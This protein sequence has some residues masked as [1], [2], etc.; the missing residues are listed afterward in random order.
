MP[1]RT[2]AGTDRCP[3]PA[4]S[5]APMKVDFYR[6]TLGDDELES[7]RATLG[8][9]FLT[10]GPRVGRFEEAFAARL[11]VPFVVGC[12]SCTTGLTL[13][14]RAMDIGPGDEVITTPMTFCSTSNTIH[15]IGARHVFADIDPETGILDPERVKDKITEKTKAIAVVHLYGQLAP[16]KAFRALADAHGL[17][18]IEDAAH[19]VESE[20]E[21]VT[22][23]Q[24][25]DAAIFSFYA[26]KVMT[27]GDG[28]AIAV[29]DEGL[30]DR[31]RRL[32]NHG[33]SKDAAA[34]HGGLYQHWDM[35]ELGYKAAMTD[36]EAALLLPQ[37][38]RIDAQ[39]AS[40]TALVERYEH[41]LADHPDLELVARNGVS[42]HHLMTVR[43]PRGL[44]DAVLTGLGQRQVGCAVNYRAVHTLH[45]YREQF[46]YRTEDFPRAA[47]WGDRTISLPLY[48]GMPEAHVD[49]ACDAL[50]AALTD[51]KAQAA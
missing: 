42:G 10:L 41:I 19:A 8:S 4:L 12:S 27:S 17:Y 37:L 5:S 13:A 40:R 21:G 15:H 32:R 28:G 35:M 16:M 23:G 48:P 45:W 6:H 18:L 39:H 24:L 14:M 3:R 47:D 26:T 1:R 36:V 30:R 46:G 20:R 38:D 25:G 50:D 31:L 11:G 22:V 51:A 43:V 33:V 7:I 44:R 2:G 34:R 29:H 9:L 49:A